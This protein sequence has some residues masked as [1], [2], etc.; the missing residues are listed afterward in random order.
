MK[1]NNLIKDFKYKIPNQKT[2]AIIILFMATTLS[3]SMGT[4][5]NSKIDKNILQNLSKNSVIPVTNSIDQS[6]YQYISNNDDISDTE[7]NNQDAKNNSPTNMDKSNDMNME[8]SSLDNTSII[9]EIPVG[10]FPAK[11]ADIL[12][13]LNLIEDKTKFLNRT[14]EIGVDKQL[15]SG[16]FKIMNNSSL[17]DI[18][19]TIANIN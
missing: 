19:K 13:E 2:T 6:D 15:K 9:V 7:S 5:F 16:T 17:D 12:L 11:I 10:T 4:A 3:W 14:V 8:T 1:K 18:I